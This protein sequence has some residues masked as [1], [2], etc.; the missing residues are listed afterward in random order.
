[1]NLKQRAA[2]RRTILAGAAS[3]TALSLALTLSAA[4]TAQ[5][6]VPDTVT[7]IVPFGAGGGVDTVTRAVADR[8]AQDLGVTVLVDN[9]PGASTMIAQTYVMGAPTDGTVLLVGTPSLSTGFALTPEAAV[10]DPRTL[11][12][13]V[14]PMAQQPYILTAGPALPESVTDVASLLDWAREN[15]G[16]L[17]LVNSGPLT[18]PRLAAE[19]MGYMAEVP[20]V[21][22]S[23]QAGSQ[24]AL[25]VAAGRVHAG[26]NQIVEALPQI[27]AGNLRPLA[28]TS[29][30][31]SPNYPDLPAVSE[32]LEGF[33]V[34]S[35]NGVFAPAGTPDE[36]L[37]AYNA[38]FN[39]VFQD[40]SLREM[41][42]PAGTEFVGGSREDLATRLDSEIQRWENLAQEVDLAIE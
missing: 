28:V 15:P 24:G 13:T 34:A 8:L 5:A 26:I 36:V 42:A 22:I 21:T 25:D 6:Q 9:R 19:L 27:E 41:F 31:R 7:I 17:D 23:Y 40:E 32:T 29:L 18:A 4:G 14:T 30:N 39:R 20:M 11:F 33:D 10:G 3:V 1:M 16:E 2:T 35:W 37:D 12:D 38:A